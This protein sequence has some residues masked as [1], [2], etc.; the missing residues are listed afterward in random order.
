MWGPG[1]EHVEFHHLFRHIR[2]RA[3]LAPEMRVKISPL[4][5]IYKAQNFADRI[6]YTYR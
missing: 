4:L 3:E 6:V 1:Q 5:W 2:L